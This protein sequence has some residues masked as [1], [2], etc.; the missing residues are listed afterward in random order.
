M[1]SAIDRRGLRGVLAALVTTVLVMTGSA[2]AQA[3]AQKGSTAPP[4]ALQGFSQNRNQPV[5]INAA[6]LDVRDRAKMATFSGNVQLVQGDTTLRCKTLTVHYDGDQAAPGPKTATPGAGA[7]AASNSQI[8]HMEAIGNVI[9]TQ[10]EQT[11]TGDRAVYDMKQDTV[12]LLAAP[13]SFVAVTQGV[14]IVRSDKS[15]IVHLASGVSHFDG[16]VEALI[17]P[18][19]TKG[20]G[21]GGESKTP[22]RAAPARSQQQGGQ[23]T[24]ATPQGNQ[25]NPQGLY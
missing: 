16:R 19:A 25:G 8:S 13:G 1:R 15:L 21:V 24:Q 20:A 7:G 22:P 4:N 2:H 23:G 12:T 6:S 10:K 14:N 11:A 17:T 18:N 5:K 3:P 9:V